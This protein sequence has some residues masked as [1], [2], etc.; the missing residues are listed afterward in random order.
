MKSMLRVFILAGC[1]ASVCGCKLNGADSLLGPDGG[2]AHLT[3]PE[4][5]VSEDG[6]NVTNDAGQIGEQHEQ[7]RTAHVTLHMAGVK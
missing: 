5:P 3:S 1:V 7:P 4:K 2:F 6:T